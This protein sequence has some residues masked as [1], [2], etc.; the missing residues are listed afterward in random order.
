MFGA[1]GS[2]DGH[3]MMGELGLGLCSFSIGTSMEHLAERVDKYRAGMARCET[4]VAAYKNDHV[5]AFTMVNCA[6]KKQDS[7]AAARDAYEWY[8]RRSADT[9]GDLSDWVESRSGEL[10]TYGY[11][12]KIRTAARSGSKEV[13]LNFDAMMG[14]NSVIAGDPDEIV[15]RAKQYEAAG[16]DQLLCLLDPH[17]IPQENI[18][19]TI[20]LVGKHV[21]PEFS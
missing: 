2:I 11:T 17:D 15:E 10:G 9:I 6:P 7:Y 13:A 16:V 20:E 8:A 21:I 12:D 4:P 1:T 3:E 5:V 18:L 19:Q 14:R